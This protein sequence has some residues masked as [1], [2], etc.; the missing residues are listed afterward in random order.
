[1]LA[2]DPAIIA[3]VQ[4]AARRLR[5]PPALV[6]GCEREAL[7]HLAAPGE[8]PRH[9]VLEP[10]ATGPGW[11]LL[12][13]T[14][15]DPTARTGLVLV[16]GLPSEVAG[17]GLAV[18]PADAGRVAAALQAPGE[19]RPGTLPQGGAAALRAGLSKGEVLVRYQPIVRITDRRPVLVEA[20]AR[21]Q[22]APQ[23]DPT[24]PG[25]AAVSPGAFMPL[26]ERSGLVRALSVLVASRAAAELAPLRRRFGGLGGVSVNLPLELLL[27][28]DLPGWLR[29]ALRGTGLRPR[30]MALELTE[31][32][33]VRDLP[34][35]R[36]ALLR[37]RTAGH[38][39][40]L[41]DVTLGDG[42][43]ALLGLPFAG[44]KLDRGL[45][46]ALPRHA[47][48]RREV[49]R[50]VRLAEAR[51]Q[52]VIAEGVSGRRLWAAVRA[53]GVPLAQG[54]GIGRPLPAA[55]LASWAASWQG[56]RQ[57]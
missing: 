31:T 48:A 2:R 25:G 30:H 49:R 28:P 54:F 21:W 24:Q 37:L 51:G 27:Q 1:M 50:L 3:A 12:L 22:P 7:A 35:L 34:T 44:L 39:V 57:G 8:G 9:L 10:A 14:L 16:S 42:R 6:T 43:E 19:R 53:L 52:C 55:A 5:Q 47:Q 29:E 40:L 18:L 13:E 20:L 41:D 38:P 23:G 46:E 56:Y 33:P 26:A 45:V 17:P 15:S 32:T 36:R 11:P 4:A